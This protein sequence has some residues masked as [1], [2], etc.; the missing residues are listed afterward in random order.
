MAFSASTCCVMQRHLA[1]KRTFSETVT[2][3]RRYP[4]SIEAVESRET[5]GHNMGTSKRRKRLKWS[6][7]VLDRTLVTV[8]RSHHAPEVETARKKPKHKKKIEEAT[9]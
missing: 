7:S 1:A 2:V 9:E 8:H 6:R 3:S 5:A 4:G